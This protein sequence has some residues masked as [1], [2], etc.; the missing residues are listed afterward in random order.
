MVLVMV[1]GGI[2]TPEL[3][4]PNQLIWLEQI[5]PCQVVDDTV[6]GLSKV[7][8]VF[9]SVCLSIYLYI[10]QSCIVN[11]IFGEFHIGHSY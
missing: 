6:I 3:R 8:R 9:L 2:K 11:T 7:S 10:Y 4:N 1:L 5:I